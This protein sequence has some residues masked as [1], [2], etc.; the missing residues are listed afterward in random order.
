M[1]QQLNRLLTPNLKDECGTFTM[2]GGQ[3]IHELQEEDIKIG[4][5]VHVHLCNIPLPSNLLSLI[6]TFKKTCGKLFV[7]QEE[8]CDS[9]TKIQALNFVLEGT[10]KFSSGTGHFCEKNST[11]FL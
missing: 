11:F 3:Y 9:V 5:I 7:Y 1:T 2:Q 8:N 10:Q 4:E 6:F